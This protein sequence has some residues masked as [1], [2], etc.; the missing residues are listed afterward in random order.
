MYRQI[1]SAFYCLPG[2]LIEQKF[3]H[4]EEEK[5]EILYFTNWQ[6]KRDI[7]GYTNAHL[8]LGVG[9]SNY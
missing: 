5:I 9:L 6:R 4:A 1:P 8:L 7:C 3:N 2:G